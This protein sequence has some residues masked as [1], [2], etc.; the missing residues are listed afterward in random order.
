MTRVFETESHDTATRDDRGQ[1]HRRGDPS[2]PRLHL[3]GAGP[4]RRGADHV[5]AG[6]RPALHA[7]HRRPRQADPRS[8]RGDARSVRRPPAESVLIAVSPGQRVVEVVTGAGAARRLPD[9]AC[10]LAVLSMTGSFAAGDLVGRHRQRAAAALRPGR[11]PAGL[12]HRTSH[13]GRQDR[14]AEAVPTGAELRRLDRGVGRVAA[15]SAGRADRSHGVPLPGA[16]RAGDAVAALERPAGAAA[17]AGRRRRA[18]RRPPRSVRG[19]TT[20]GNRYCTAFLAISPGRRS[21][22]GRI[23]A[24]YRST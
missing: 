14:A 16:Q 17:P 9:R 13:C 2:R 3:P 1:R 6:D 15:V 10:A 19:S 18:R 24:K 20:G 11:S 21:H 7:L 4:P 23:S 22:S 12:R 8:G 5:L